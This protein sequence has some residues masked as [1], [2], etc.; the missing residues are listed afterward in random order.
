MVGGRSHG[1]ER[2]RRTWRVAGRHVIMRIDMQDSY[3]EQSDWSNVID[4]VVGK[5]VNGTLFDG[6]VVTK[7]IFRRCR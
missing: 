4:S 7:R 5:T 3:V 2:G 1:K 6:E